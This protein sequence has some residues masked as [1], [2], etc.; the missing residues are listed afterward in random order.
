MILQPYLREHV[1][2]LTARAGFQPLILPLIEVPT[3]V[4]KQKEITDDEG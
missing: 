2:A 3:L 4:Q 1:F